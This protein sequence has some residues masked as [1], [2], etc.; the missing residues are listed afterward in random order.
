M[1]VQ[2]VNKA[3]AWEPEHNAQ[4]AILCYQNLNVCLND[5]DESPLL[6]FNKVGLQTVEKSMLTTVI[7]NPI[8]L[9]LDQ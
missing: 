5:K 8:Y 9:G 7:S 6:L 1:N 3:L 4:T 2:L